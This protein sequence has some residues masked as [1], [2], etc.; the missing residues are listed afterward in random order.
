MRFSDSF[1]DYLLHPDEVLPESRKVANE[2][3]LRWDSYLNALMRGMDP[4]SATISIP[5][6]S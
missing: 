3:P 2:I 4:A 5:P 1:D 6:K